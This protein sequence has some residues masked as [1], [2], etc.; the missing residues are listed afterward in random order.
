ML[1]KKPPSLHISRW[2]LLGS[3]ATFKCALL[4]SST[5]SLEESNSSG[6]SETSSPLISILI[7]V[8]TQRVAFLDLSSV[9]S[10]SVN[11]WSAPE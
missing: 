11:Q 3:K 2:E 9:T 4:V 8:S 1:G 10:L 5:L 7:K 6:E